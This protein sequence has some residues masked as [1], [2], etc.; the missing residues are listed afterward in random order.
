MA[1]AEPSPLMWV[2]AVLLMVSL[3]LVGRKRRAQTQTDAGASQV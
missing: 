2:S 1:S 3:Y